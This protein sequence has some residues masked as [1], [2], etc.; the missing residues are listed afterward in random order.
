MFSNVRTCV[1][2]E[3]FYTEFFANNVGLMQG[4]VI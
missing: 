3:G 4:E 1:S 2:V